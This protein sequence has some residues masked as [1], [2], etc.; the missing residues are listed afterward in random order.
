VEGPASLDG[1]RIPDTGRRALQ[2]VLA[3]QAPLPSGARLVVA[4]FA[5]PPIAGVTAGESA[6]TGLSLAVVVPWN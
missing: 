3:L 6:T 4:T 2:G 5:N 1:Q